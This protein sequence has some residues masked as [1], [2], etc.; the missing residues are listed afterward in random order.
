MWVT[1]NDKPNPLPDN[2]YIQVIRDRGNKQSTLST[3]SALQGE[4]LAQRWSTS[5][6]LVDEQ[7]IDLVI[8]FV[9]NRMETSVVA[10]A[11]ERLNCGDQ[12]KLRQV[13]DF[14]GI[15]DLLQ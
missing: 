13:L 10:E 4:A 1:R 12:L 8:D 3:N 11:D 15:S 2:R 6:M 9:S 7:P 5:R 14:I